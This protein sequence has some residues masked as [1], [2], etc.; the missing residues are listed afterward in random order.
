MTPKELTGLAYFLGNVD[1]SELADAGVLLRNPNGHP[2]VGG[3]N[4][5]RFQADLVT[6]IIKLPPQ[7]LDALC[8]LI[9]RRAP[10]YT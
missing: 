4:W 8:T 2:A 3:S 1:F 6:F 7:R 10:A 9:N 5:E